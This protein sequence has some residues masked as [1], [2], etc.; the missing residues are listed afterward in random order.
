MAHWVGGVGDG[1]GDGV[2]DG[3]RDGKEVGVF[4]GEGARGQ[5]PTAMRPDRSRLVHEVPSLKARVSSTIRELS[6]VVEPLKADVA[7]SQEPCEEAG[8]STSQ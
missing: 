8:W 7:S 3:E 4:D 6:G 5:R 1:L 2:N